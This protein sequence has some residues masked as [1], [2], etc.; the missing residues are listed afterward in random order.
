MQG[1]MMQRV[2]QAAHFG[3][4]QSS[5]GQWLSHSIVGVALRSVSGSGML[6]SVRLSCMLH[7]LV[8]YLGDGSCIPDTNVLLCISSET[9]AFWGLHPH[10]HVIYL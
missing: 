3:M 10:V 6:K 4:H 8:M 7:G 1:W 5:D 9:Q 2:L